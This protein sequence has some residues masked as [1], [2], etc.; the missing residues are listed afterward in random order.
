MYYVYIL[1]NKTHRVLYIGVTRSLDARIRN[2]RDK[3]NTDSFSAQ[4]NLNKLLYYESYK[5]VGD[6]ILREKQLKVWKRA[7]KIDL[8]D[9]VNPLWIDLAENW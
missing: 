6:A 9:K 5:Y 7:W 1:T 8:I 4:Y 3:R 2:H